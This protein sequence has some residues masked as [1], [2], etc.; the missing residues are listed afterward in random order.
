[1]NFTQQ[2]ILCDKQEKVGKIQIDFEQEKS[3]N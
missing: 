2:A 1:M 3:N